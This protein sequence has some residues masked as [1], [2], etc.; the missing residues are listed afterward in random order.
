VIRP[1][2]TKRFFL[3]QPSARATWQIFC[4]S[5]RTS[6]LRVRRRYAPV[7]IEMPAGMGHVSLS[8][9]GCSISWVWKCRT[10]ARGRNGYASSSGRMARSDW[11]KAAVAH[12]ELGD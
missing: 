12:N 5:V 4:L 10:E 8:G 2:M 7:R 1:I 6:P 3:C 9:R 11:M